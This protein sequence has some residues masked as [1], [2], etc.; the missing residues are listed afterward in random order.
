V[1][2]VPDCGVAAKPSCAAE[3]SCDCGGHGWHWGHHWN[4]LCHKGRHFWHGCKA[5]WSCA[6]GTDVSCACGVDTKGG[7]MAPAPAGDQPPAPL[8]EAEATSASLEEGE[9]EVRKIKLPAVGTG[10]K[11][12]FQR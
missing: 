10:L 4:G 5:H 1:A 9:R 12:V 6:C 11:S 2:K 3:P 8:P 7:Y